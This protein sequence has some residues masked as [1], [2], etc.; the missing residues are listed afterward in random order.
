MNTLKNF[1]KS[2]FAHIL[3]KKLCNYSDSRLLA[4]NGI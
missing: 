3:R 2:D 1:V 4:L